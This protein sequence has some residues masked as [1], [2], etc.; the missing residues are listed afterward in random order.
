MSAQEIVCKTNATYHTN[1]CLTQKPKKKHKP[2]N[3]ST[4]RQQMPG[5]D[6]QRQVT[7]IGIRQRKTMCQ[8]LSC[9][10]DDGTK[11][12]HYRHYPVQR[13]H[14]IALQIE[15]ADFFSSAASHSWILSWVCQPHQP[16]IFTVDY[17]ITHQQ[18]FQS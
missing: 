7:C 3:T 2:N 1:P 16:H 18:S 5:T 17:P 12:T 6:F 10:G 11:F 8:K 4:N 13:A 15:G 14:D 9:T